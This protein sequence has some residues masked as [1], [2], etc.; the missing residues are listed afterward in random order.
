MTVE[1]M[2]TKDDVKSDPWTNRQERIKQWARVPQLL[3]AGRL[4]NE[5]QG[6]YRLR[7]STVIVE[8]KK[9]VWEIKY[10][11]IGTP[12]HVTLW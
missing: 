1:E 10:D 6:W 2:T 8:I 11:A 9:I 4:V 5:G 12:T 7:D 3:Q